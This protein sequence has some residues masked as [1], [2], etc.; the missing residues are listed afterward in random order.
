MSV[1]RLVTYGNRLYSQTTYATNIDREHFFLDLVE[2]LDL[3]DGIANTEILAI[4]DSISFSEIL[5]LTLN[6]TSLSDYIVLTEWLNITLTKP[7]IWGTTIN[8]GTTWTNPAE[9]SSSKWTNQDGTEP[10]N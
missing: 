6:L 1:R 10:V 7:N 5:S 8:P 2:L 3:T 9:P 4:N